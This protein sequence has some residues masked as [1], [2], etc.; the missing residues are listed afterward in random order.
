MKKIVV[1]IGSSV[2]APQ[3][4]ID[5]EKMDNIIQD[6]IQ[7]EKKEIKTVVVSSGAIACG[8]NKLGWRK[9]PSDLASL[10]ALASVGQINL[11]NI[12][13][14][15]F[16]QYNKVC[17]QILLTWDD[18]NDRKRYLNAR[19]TINK[20]L[21][22]GIIP[23]INENDTISNEE[24]K[25]GDNDRLSA[26]VS[27]LLSADFLVI[28]SDV[29]GLFSESGLVKVVKEIDEKIMG[30][31]KRENKIFL[32]KGKSLKGKKGKQ[33]KDSK[34]SPLRVTTG[35]M[36]TK[37]E[38][39]KIATAAG[40]KTVIAN[41]KVKGVISK[42]I[43]EEVG[44]LFLPTKII[45]KSRKRWIAFSKKIKGRVYIDEGAKEAILEKGKSLLAVGIN[46]VEGEFVSGD[47]VEILDEK[48]E[49]IGCGIVNYSFNELKN[50][51]GKRLEKEVVHRDNF[52]RKGGE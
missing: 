28:L 25:F 15:R 52:V 31:A 5:E 16:S 42:A 49:V 39:A 35:G 2:I 10:Q 43:K 50:L 26:L 46:K 48:G 37:L 14:E 30:L 51:N 23:I 24:I 22:L 45:S 7:L 20:V 11:M 36:V 17:A 40:I 29:D 4:K 27:D 41:G 34:S 32:S 6:I 47:S 33:K 21:Q 9:K 1:K 44:T 12:Y 8:L 13:R 18:F 38:A 19:N 3:G